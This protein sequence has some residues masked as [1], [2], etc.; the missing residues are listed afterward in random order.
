LLDSALDKINL[1]YKAGFI[2]MGQIPSSIKQ[3]VLYH[4]AEIYDKQ[5]ISSS[6]MDEVLR[7]YK[8][9]RKILI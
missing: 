6:F 3:G 7:F 8:P 5:V 9:F 1:I 2:D 4:V